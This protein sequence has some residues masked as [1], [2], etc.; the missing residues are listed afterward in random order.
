MLDYKTDEHYH[1]K[2][3]GT[4]M[5]LVC[6]ACAVIGLFVYVLFVWPFKRIK[7]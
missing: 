5:S 6:F 2:T 3:V 7:Q 4:L 1:G